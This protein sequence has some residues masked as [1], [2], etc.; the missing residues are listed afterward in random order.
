MI[1]AKVGQHMNCPIECL[2]FHQTLIQWLIRSNSKSLNFIVLWNTWALFRCV[3][4]LEFL[5][6]KSYKFKPGYWKYWYFTKISGLSTQGYILIFTF[7]LGRLFT[8]MFTEIFIFSSSTF[9]EYSPFSHLHH[10][11]FHPLDFNQ[12]ICHLHQ[13]CS[14]TVSI[15]DVAHE[16]RRHGQGIEDIEIPKT[17]PE[18]CCLQLSKTGR[19]F[20]VGWTVLL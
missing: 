15:S 12:N 19:S 7:F 1:E 4:N 20:S 14:Y 16:K 2:L 13:S 9:L 17:F 6:K 8:E 18:R 5:C 10:Q 3:R 11:H